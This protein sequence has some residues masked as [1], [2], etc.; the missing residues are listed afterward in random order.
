MVTNVDPRSP[1]PSEVGPAAMGGYF[2]LPDNYEVKNGKIVTLLGNRDYETAPYKV[3]NKYLAARSN[4]FG[5]ANYGI[6]PTP[7][8]LG[9]ELKIERK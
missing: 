7:A 2:G 6:V 3:G 1:R 9:T 8:F 5:S 4:E